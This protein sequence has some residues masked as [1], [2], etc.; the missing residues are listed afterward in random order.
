LMVYI[1]DTVKNDATTPYSHVLNA[2]SVAT[3]IPIIKVCS[4]KRNIP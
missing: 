4:T 3:N 2:L 1:K